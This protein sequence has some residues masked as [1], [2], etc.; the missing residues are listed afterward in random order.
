ML[1]TFT[2][3]ADLSRANIEEVEGK[4]DKFAASSTWGDP[5]ILPQADRGELRFRMAA[6]NRD[7]AVAALTKHLGVPVSVLLA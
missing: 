5:A 2:F 4:L 7:D 1:T 6:S 3:V